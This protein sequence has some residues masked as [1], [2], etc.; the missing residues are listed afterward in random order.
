MKNSTHFDP[1]LLCE[2]GPAETRLAVYRRG[3][4]TRRAAVLLEG[5]LAE[6]L[7]YT[8]EERLA[9]QLWYTA[10]EVQRPPLPFAQAWPSTFL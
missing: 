1:L 3:E 10:E 4:E 2:S 7:S 5:R 6:Q 8:A 9:E